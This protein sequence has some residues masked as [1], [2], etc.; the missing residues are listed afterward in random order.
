MHLRK[1]EDI[2]SEIRSSPS[3]G[4]EESNFISLETSENLLLMQ[5]EAL[6]FI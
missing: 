4:K 2:I 3:R 6:V 1:C 5:L